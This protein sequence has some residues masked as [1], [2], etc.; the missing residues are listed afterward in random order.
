MG[1]QEIIL[2]IF[3]ILFF[4]F[5]GIDFFFCFKSELYRK[6]FKCFPLLLLII[7]VAIIVPNEP[8]IYTAFICGM[9]GDF[10]LISWN[11]KIFLVG[12]AFFLAEHILL[13]TRLYLYGN[14]NLEW[15]FYMVCA[16][17]LLLVLFFSYIFVSTY[18]KPV[19][20]ISL[21]CYLYML[22]M[23][24]VLMIAI[25]ITTNNHYFIIGTFGYLL[26]IISDFL[27]MQKRFIKKQKFHQPTIM[28]TYYTAQYFIALTLLLV[29]VF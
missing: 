13:S 4:V 24:L 1:Q 5:S 23:N 3:S 28:A 17:S 10:L 19:F 7:L 21:S 26:F 11:K 27:V 25:S 6:I 14:F 2:I 20:L 12:T 8:L 15:P 9:I 16:G 22:L 18:L 29:L